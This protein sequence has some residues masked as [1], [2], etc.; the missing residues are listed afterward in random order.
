M[1]RLAA[2]PAI[3]LASV[4]TCLAGCL[5]I[6]GPRG[7]TPNSLG[8]IMSAP[9]YAPIGAARVASPAA[10]SS[11]FGTSVVYVSL[12]PGSV[13]AGVG[14]T[15]TNQATGLSVTT[16]VVG[17]GFDPVPL[18]ASVGDTVVVDI[19]GTASATLAR[20][21]LSVVAYHV[22]RIVRTSP[23][24]G[25]R[26][27][28]LNSTLVLVFSE[29]VDPATVTTGSVQ[30]WRDTTPVAGTV[31]L[32]DV[33]RTTAEF[34]PADLLARLTDY[35]LTA[36]QAIR[37]VSGQA[38]GSPV[39]VRFTTGVSVAAQAAAKLA[40][41]VQPSSTTAGVAI[42]PAVTVTI[43]DT[44]GNTVASATN[45]VT[46]ASSCAPSSACDS[47]RSRGLGWGGLSGTIVVQAV[48]GVATFRDLWLPYANTGYTLTAS[49]SPLAGATSAP[50]DIAPG[51]PVQLYFVGVSNATVAQPIAF[52]HVA[53]QDKFLNTVTSARDA[54][55]L[56]L[57]A[58]PAGATL[59]GTLTVTAA[60]G[61]ASFPNLSLDRPGGYTLAATAGTLTGAT[62]NS[63]FVWSAG[64]FVAVSAGGTHTCGLTYAGAA[65]CWGGNDHGQLGDGTTTLRTSPVSVAGGLTFARLVAGGSHTCGVQTGG[66]TY[67]WGLNDHGQLGD[68]TTTDRTIP[69]PVAGGLS[70]VALSAGGTHTCGVGPWDPGSGISVTYCWGL[71]ASGQLGDGTT[72]ER[73]KPQ[74][75]PGTS[76]SVVSAGLNHTC[77]L[78]LDIGGDLCWG[79]NDNG[80]LGDGTTIGKTSPVGICFPTCGA[81]A[82]FNALSAGGSH[83]CAE[84]GSF[85]PGSYYVSFAAYCWGA[86]ANGQLGDG[87]TTQR[88]SPVLV[89]G[90]LSFAVDGV[91]GGGQHTCGLAAAGAGIPFNLVT[92]G[93]AYC[94]GANDNGQLGDGTTTQRTSPVPVGGGLSFVVVSAGGS[95]TCGLTAGA[96]YCWGLN[97]NGQ[98]GTGTTTSSSV[99]VKVAGQP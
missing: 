76:G 38:L 95:H 91:S 3:V 98:L 22:P 96:A 84:A 85:V 55:T 25:G 58:H 32:G 43:Q 87:T 64:A 93:T 23:P 45:A 13:P 36:S 14:A 97:S 8:L 7:T 80:Q 60:N 11:T 17:G 71:N 65:Y 24:S 63:F 54:V 56:T 49:T 46:L 34:H 1:G 50:F 75:V 72:T 30:L 33:Y 18:A 52:A 48:N 40:F 66:A 78:N 27:V 31:R 88:T 53:I 41:T 99:P 68:G 5:D 89:G 2:V 62:S 15:I 4:L 70:F 39:D 77:G 57:A 83:T 51:A 35:R 26:D 37:N 79:G 16:V 59:A 94:W 47:T 12:P 82:T 90:G 67:C 74:A 9:V 42:S 20:V 10:S 61:V 44:A 6:P 21:R 19:A 29:P 86:N 81:L 92:A 69:V 28:P 73:T